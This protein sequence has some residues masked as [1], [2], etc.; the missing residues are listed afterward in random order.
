MI[1]KRWNGTAFVEEFPKTKAQLVF[2]NGN[3]TSVFDS[4]DKIKPTFL[5][6]SVFDSLI[7]YSGTTGNVQTAQTREILA[8]RLLNA[9]DEAVGRS[10]VGFYFVITA[11]GTISDVTGIVGFEDVRY[12][13]LRFRPTDAGSNTTP[14]A[15]SGVLEVGDW[16]VIEG[17]T[18]SGT[19]GSPFIFTV[20]VVNNAYELATTAIDGIVRLSSQSIYANLSGNNVVTDGRLKTLIDN[21]SFAGSAHVHGSINNN[22]TVTTNT[23]PSSGQHLV[24]TSTTDVVQQSSIELGTSTT[25]FLNNAGGWTAPTGT[26]VHPTQTAIDVNATDNGIN[27]IDRVQVNTLGHVTAVSTR[28]LS[29]A[30]TSAAGVMSAADKTKLDGIAASA[31]N[32][33]HP[34]H[35]GD[36]TSVGD[37]ATTI[38]GLA[39]TTAKIANSGVTFAK[40]QDMVGLSIL[41]RDTN[42]SGVTAAITA[43]AD[44]TVLRRVSGALSFGAIGGSM[45]NAN[46]VT[47]SN[48]S[49]MAVNTIKGRITAGTGSPQDLSAA[50]VR[51]IIELAAPIYVQTATP[52]TTVT[53]SLWYDIN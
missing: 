22:G 39:V 20:S 23:A 26:F 30:T 25:T 38:A 49:N 14:S 17:V 50:N 53:H 5:P 10:V 51:T 48:L 9:Y 35:S 42:T 19:V 1:I 18:G 40:F 7:F 4:N 27:V 8:G 46:T 16:F 29:N 47:N 24:I 43:G 45:I 52:T 6:D 28:D 13:T 15:S 11:G 2:N 37:G 32:Y 34:N 31:N 44:D 36:V 3:T 33:S 21:A 41:G 12:V